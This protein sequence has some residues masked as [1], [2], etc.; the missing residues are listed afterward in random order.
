MQGLSG[1]SAQTPTR[2]VLDAGQVYFNIDL[3][4]LENPAEQNPLGQALASAI[5]LG[6]TRG[7]ATFN[8][9]LSVREIEVD[10]RLGPVKG[11]SRREEVRPSLTVSFV[12]LTYQNLEKAIAGAVSTTTGQFRKITGGPILPQHYIPN[13]ALIAAYAGTQNPLVVVVKNALV[14][15]GF[16]FTAEDKNEV[17]VEVTFVGHFDPANLAEEPWAIYHPQTT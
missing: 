10:G 16:D 9:N 15:E 8:R 12:E 7:G 5:A 6:A 17:A 11:L 2:L 13:V 1:L 14:V 3:T 4:A